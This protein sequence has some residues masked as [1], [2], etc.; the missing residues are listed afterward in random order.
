MSIWMFLYTVPVD[1]S[2]RASKPFFFMK[3][4]YKGEFSAQHSYLFPDNNT[5]FLDDADF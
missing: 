3:S 5:I 2:N 1:T 4:N